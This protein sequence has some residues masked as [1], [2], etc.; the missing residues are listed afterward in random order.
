MRYYG[1]KVYFKILFFGTALAGKTTSLR[2][3][4]SNVIPRD[5]KMTSEIKSIETSF[6]QTLLFDFTPIQIS[7]H[8]VVRLFTATGQDYYLS[9]RR[10]LFEDADGIFFVV[11]CQKKELEH[12]REFVVEF[13]RYLDGSEKLRRSE[14]IILYN[15]IDLEDTYP[16]R[17]LGRLL[18]L[19]MYPGYEVSALKG[20]NLRESFIV[21]VRRLLERL[22][23]EARP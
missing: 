17:E 3:L 23:Q 14:I 12:N 20:I 10:M 15:K 2:W 1:N 21:M 5:M 13:N 16:A 9:T 22:E 6:G 19:E 18:N 4:Y 7:P 8:I 11:D